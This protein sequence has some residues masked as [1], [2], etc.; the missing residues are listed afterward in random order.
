MGA[1]IQ[2]I[3]NELYKKAREA[4][5]GIRK[6]DRAAV[7]LQAIVSAKEHGVN[8]VSKVLNIA[9]NTL[10]NWIKS[11]NNGG[12]DALADEVGRGRKSKIQEVHREAILEYVKQDCNVTIQKILLM[13]REKFGLESSKSGVHRTLKSL[14]LSY[15]TPRPR[16]YK[17]DPTQKAEFKKKSR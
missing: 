15:I 14:N 8:V 9:S 16:H 1:A 5:R 10:R 13:L 4:L 11:F 12:I 6:T 2:L 17:Q 7:R 3:T